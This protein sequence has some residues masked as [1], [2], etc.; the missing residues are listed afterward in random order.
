M[1]IMHTFKLCTF[2]VNAVFVNCTVFRVRASSTLKMVE[3]NGLSLS[4]NCYMYSC[5]L[6]PYYRHCE[7]MHI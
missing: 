1:V 7:Y 4:V 2:L 5:A 3:T 6:V